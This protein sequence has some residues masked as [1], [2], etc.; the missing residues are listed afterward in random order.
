M[1]ALATGK[2]ATDVTAAEVTDTLCRLLGMTSAFFFGL[3][4]NRA[5]CLLFFYVMFFSDPDFSL[6]FIAEWQTPIPLAEVFDS[7]H[8][9]W[10]FSS[11]TAEEDPILSNLS[12]ADL[13]II[14]FDR[15]AMDT[16]FGRTSWSPSPSSR[17]TKGM[18]MRDI[19]F[20][21]PW[22]RVRTM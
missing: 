22:I 20:Q 13:D 15:R 2:R 14:H 11:F 12:S 4:T 6:K 17:L 16:T 21:S 18:E 19:A 7:P 10:S 5:V 8:V 3:I 9:D 1:A